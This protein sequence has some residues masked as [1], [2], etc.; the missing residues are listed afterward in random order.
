VN[1]YRRTPILLFRLTTALACAAAQAP[2]T[3]PTAV[4]PALLAKATAGDVIAEVQAGDAYSAG[5]GSPRDAR[6]RAADYAQ[7]ALWYRKAA[8]Q[9]SIPAQVHLAELYRDGRGMPR[10][11]E[12]AVAWYRKAADKGDAGAQGSL[13]LLYSVGMG[14]PQD[15]VEAYYW[16]CVAA[17][18]PGPNQA[19]YA[20]NRQSVGEHITTDQQSAVED[21]VAAWKA[22][23]PRPGAAPGMNPPG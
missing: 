14:I 15:Y 17:A 1:L 10:D 13:G 22:A 6:Q 2:V 20:T 7:A 19:K 21:R 9:G 16:L 12:Q 4:D 8:D 5:N 11:M 18:V 23:H 3:P